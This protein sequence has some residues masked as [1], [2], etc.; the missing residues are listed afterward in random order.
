MHTMTEI[1]FLA[2]AAP[3][4]GYTARAAGYDI[5]T[6]ADTLSGLHAMLNDALRCHF[7]EGQAPGLICLQI[8]LNPAVTP[9]R[10]HAE[11]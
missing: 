7:D 5:Y 9:P 1:L 2:Q 3:S 10:S 11:P 4:G 6:E 8:N